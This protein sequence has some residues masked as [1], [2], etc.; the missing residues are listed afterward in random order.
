V[1]LFAAACRGGGPARIAY[2][3]PWLS[4]VLAEVAQPAI[5]AWGRPRAAQIVDA[6]P[7]S[8]HLPSGYGGD[9]AFAE[10]TA[11]M[12]GL[13][14]AVGPQSSRATLLAAPIYVE[15]RIPLIAPTATSRFVGALG[16]WVF[17]LAPDDRAEGAFMADFALDRLH[18]RRITIFYL[19]SDEYGLGLRD[20][21]VLALR[22]RGV[23]P[24]DES[25]IIEESEL[26][27]RVAESLRRAR[28]DAVVIAARAREAAAIARALEA[29]QPH[30]P[31]IVGD[32]APLDAWF[33]AAAGPA[34]ASVYGVAWWLPDQPDSASRAFVA[35]W[36]RVDRA[37]P[38]AADAMYYDA[39]MVAARAVR[40]GGSSR[41][42]VRRY[43]S[44]LG[45]T[46]PPYRGVTGPIAFGPHRAVNLLMTTLAPDGRTVAVGA[47][48][49][50]P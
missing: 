41:A 26:P 21:V 25:G 40:D 2:P 15:R 30:T 42:A 22:R 49:G 16:P 48:G 6:Y 5:D 4:P 32:G 50:N 10:A 47:A 39:L 45:V 11:A 20:G 37:G 33:R 46:R 7:G 23:A 44:E 43:L 13:V 1:A 17:Q 35:R 31:V 36:A 8:R 27:R 12:P 38:S 14:A 34:A 29:R 3:L 19:L 28:P 9:V 18:A 24:V